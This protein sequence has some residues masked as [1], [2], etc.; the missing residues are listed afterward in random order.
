[1]LTVGS[2]SVKD[3]NRWN[4]FD[5][6]INFWRHSQRQ[7]FLLNQTSCA[8]VVSISDFQRLLT[9]TGSSTPAKGAADD[10]CRRYQ[11]RGAS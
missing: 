8:S 9:C 11:P 3:A 1:M 10:Y 4:L 2:A 7:G 6:E 5:P